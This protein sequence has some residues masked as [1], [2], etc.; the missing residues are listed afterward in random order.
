MA[1]SLPV[2][3]HLSTVT[4][5]CVCTRAPIDLII[6]GGENIYPA[7]VQ[8]VLLGIPGVKDAY[9]FGTADETWGI[10]LWR[11]SRPTIL[12]K[13]SPATKKSLESTLLRAA[14]VRQRV[15]RNTPI[16][17]TII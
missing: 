6:S 11:S 4:V 14:F 16:W 7:E 15:H 10:A 17:C 8:D 13:P 12:P 1:I 9:V 2:T 3:E 5:F